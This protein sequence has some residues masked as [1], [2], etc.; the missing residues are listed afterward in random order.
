MLGFFEWFT[1][2]NN[3]VFIVITFLMWGILGMVHESGWKQRAIWFCIAGLLGASTLG[4][5]ITWDGYRA[6]KNHYTTCSKPEAVNAFYVFDF[7]RERC[8]RPFVG[9]V[10][11]NEHG[12]LEIK[13]AKKVSKQNYQLVNL[14]KE[15]YNA[16]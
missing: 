4:T 11:V 12:N 7:K 9:F 2:H 15:D 16:Y 8:L 5:A 13:E 6:Y 10:P 14:K 3:W 1:I